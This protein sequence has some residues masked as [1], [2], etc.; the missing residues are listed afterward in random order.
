MFFRFE[1]FQILVTLAATELEKIGAKKLHNLH[2]LMVIV[3]KQL[4]VWTHLRFVK[5]SGD[6]SCRMYCQNLYHLFFTDSY[7]VT[8][9]FTCGFIMKG[10]WNCFLITIKMCWDIGIFKTIL[11]YGLLWVADIFLPTTIDL[12]LSPT[13]GDRLAPSPLFFEDI[14]LNSG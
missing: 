5:T 6:V 7:C 12:T 2:L 9:F 13:A 1:M 4:L 10:R 11:H 3:S 8:K 14:S